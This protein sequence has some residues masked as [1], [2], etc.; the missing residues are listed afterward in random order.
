MPIVCQAQKVSGIIDAIWGGYLPSWGVGGHTWAHVSPLKGTDVKR[1]CIRSLSDRKAD[2]SLRLGL[3]GTTQRHP[4]P[5]TPPLD[6]LHT[7]QPYLAQAKV[8]AEPLIPFQ[9]KEILTVL[10][11]GNSPHWL[12]PLSISPVSRGQFWVGPVMEDTADSW[13]RPG[14]W[15]GH[16][17]STKRLTGQRERSYFR[18]LAFI[19][20]SPKSLQ[21]YGQRQIKIQEKCMLYI[22]KKESQWAYP[23]D[24]GTTNCHLHQD[25][26]FHLPYHC[27]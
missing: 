3:G 27:K 2:P 19:R 20:L 24:A 9:P 14:T 21:M 5:H 11:C 23:K 6:T 18:R 26:K 10:S 15:N 17:I 12:Y 16:R 7:E 8:L 25:R 22:G 13:D 1:G 4:S